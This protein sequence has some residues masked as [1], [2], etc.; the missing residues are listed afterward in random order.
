MELWRVCRITGKK[1][2]SF[3]GFLNN[4]RVLN[5][6]SKFYYDLYHKQDEEGLCSE[7]KSET[8]YNS[9]SY[10]KFCSKSCANKSENHRNVVKN[11]FVGDD[12]KKNL[13]LSRRGKINTNPEKRKETVKNKCSA[14]GIDVF[15]YYSEKSKKASKTISDE[16][17][18]QIT[19][20]GIET[21]IKNETLT[22][23]SFYKD[24]FLYGK[25]INIQGYEK[26][27]LDYLQHDL[28]INDIKA[29]S[30]DFLSIKYFYG[31]QRLY[32]PDIFIPSMNL[33]IEVKSDWTYKN[34]A[35]VCDAKSSA[36]FEQG[37]NVL[38]LMITSREAR[39]CKLEGSKNL[40]DW[41]ISIQAP[42]T[43]NIRY[44][45]GSTTILNGVGPSGS[46]CQESVKDCDIV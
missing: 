44:G 21:R 3:R 19:L 34:H 11:R 38:L 42:K 46:K 17:R 36:T 5:I 43:F 28:K 29:G 8:T 22:C 30:K 7:C 1:Y 13:F 31:K 10:R 2:N 9:F 4:I 32:F 35:E 20:K 6:S 40:L 41:A 23:R 15:D 26:V 25:R 18:E 14:L 45:E 27:V 37:Y 16:R 39:K 12:E 33:V 24:Y